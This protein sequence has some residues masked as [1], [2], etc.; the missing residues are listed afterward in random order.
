M[1][2]VQGKDRKLRGQV[3]IGRWYMGLLGCAC[4]WLGVAAENA[5]LSAVSQTTKV[6]TLLLISLPLSFFLLLSGAC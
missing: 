4:L 5:K 1:N 2:E 3:G 6:G